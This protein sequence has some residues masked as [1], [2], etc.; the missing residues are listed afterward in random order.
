MS[1]HSGDKEKSFKLPTRNLGNS[2]QYFITD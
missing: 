1:F 2:K